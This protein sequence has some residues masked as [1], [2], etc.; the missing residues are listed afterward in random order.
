MSFNQPPPN[1]YGQPQQPGPPPGYGYPQQPPQAANPYAQPAQPGPYGQPPQGPPPAYGQQ[2]GGWGAPP[3]PPQ[4]PKSN[5]GKVI[6]VVAAV[7]VLAGGGIA[8]AVSSGGKGGGGGSN[9]TGGA[10]GGAPV[11]DAAKYKLTVPD[12]VDVYKLKQDQ[13]STVSST[14][15][16]KLEQNWGV[17]NGT[18]V[19]ASYTGATP[20]NSMSFV[21][22]YG[23]VANPQQSVDNAFAAAKTN[24][25]GQTDTKL[26]MTPEGS[27]QSFTPAGLDGGAVMKCQNFT[28]KG[29]TGAGLTLPFCLWADSSTVG[30]VVSV[31]FSLQ[32]GSSQAPSLSDTAALA[33]KVR[34]AARVKIS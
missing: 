13:T 6:A 34:T 18:P 12:S 5:A 11:K 21:G 15:K 31:S 29:A 28:M 33:A 2:P 4:A 14:E 7:L 20:G 23:D 3:P 27:P 32:G 8:L 22:M 1:P 9:A 25:M 17:S 19:K 24:L 16:S 26:T 10:T 30:E